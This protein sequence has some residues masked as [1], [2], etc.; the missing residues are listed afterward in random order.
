[1]EPLRKVRRIDILRDNS[2]IEIRTLKGDLLA[3]LRKQK[4][5]VW[6]KGCIDDYYP[7]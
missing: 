6:D 2:D 5:Y 1:M 3:A 7:G 4:I